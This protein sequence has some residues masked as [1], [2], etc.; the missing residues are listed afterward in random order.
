MAHYDLNNVTPFMA[1]QVGEYIKDE[2]SA[3]GMKQSELAVRTGIHAPILNDIIKGKRKITPEQSILIGCALD[4]DGDMLYNLQSKFEL[5]KARIDQK[6]VEQTRAMRQWDIM[7]QYISIDFFKHIGVLTSNVVNNVQK[8]FSIFD[9]TTVDELIELQTKDELFCFKK[10]E[11]LTANDIDMFSWKYYCKYLSRNTEISEVF[12][13]EDIDLLCSEL[14][15][16]FTKNKNTLEEATEVCRRYGI[17]MIIV[18][19]KGQVPVD[20]MSFY[21]GDNP[22][23]ILT[24]RH[25]TIDNFAFSL[26]H[27]LGHIYTHLTNNG[28]FYINIEDKTNDVSEKEA[29]E[30]AQQKLIPNDI[31]KLFKFTI[32]RTLPYKIK[33]CIEAFAMQYSINPAIVMGRYQYETKQ[34]AI[35]NNFVREI[36]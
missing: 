21:E 6:T 5:D 34:Y 9:V 11:T 17:K 28:H 2:L 4:I 20:G 31:W 8:I 29:N 10:S 23:I 33:P 30:F 25:K 36:N 1:V 18:P 27:E 14:N 26:M 22:T 12:N 15:T 3:C 13:K 16:I 32:A 19:K 35:R 7:K 24:M